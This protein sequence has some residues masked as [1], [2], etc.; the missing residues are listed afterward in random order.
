MAVYRIVSILVA[1]V[2]GLGPLGA[3][4]ALAAPPQNDNFNNWITVSDLPYVDTRDITDATYPQVG[5]PTPGC[6]PGGATYGKTVWYYLNFVFSIPR[7]TEILVST[8]GSNFDSVVAIYQTNGLGGSPPATLACSDDFNGTPQSQ[9]TWPT[10]SGHRT[11]VQVGVKGACPAEGCSL[12]LRVTVP[13]PAHDAFASAAT[14]ADPLPRE[15][16]AWTQEATTEDAGGEP[17]ITG[18]DCGLPNGLTTGRTIWYTYQPSATRE[19]VISSQASFARAVAVY[20]GGALDA[21]TRQGCRYFAAW[22]ST[23]EFRF[24]AQAGQTYRVQVGGVGSPGSVPGGFVQVNVVT[25]PPNDNFGQ[26]TTVPLPLPAEISTSSAGATVETGAGEPLPGADCG[27][28][29]ATGKTVWY[30]LTP[31]FSGPVEVTATNS[32]FDPVLAVY[33]G[34]SLGGLTR[35]GC[36]DDLD[37]NTGDAQVRLNAA[38]GTTYRIQVGGNNGGGGTFTLAVRRAPDNDDFVAAA[39]LNPAGLPV[40][41]TVDTRA[42][43]TETGE[44]LPDNACVS[45]GEGGGTEV[46][47][48]VWYRL[49]PTTNTAMVVSTADTDFQTVIAVYT[50]SAVNALTPVPNACGS[51]NDQTGSLVRFG[52]VAG[53]TYYIQIGGVGYYA[54]RGGDLRARFTVRPANDDV[55]GAST[56]P[57]AFPAEFRADT[58]GATTE[59]GEPAPDAACNPGGQETGRTLWYTVSPSPSPRTMEITTA[60]SD[61]AAFVAVYSVTGGGGFGGGLTSVACSTGSGGIGERRPGVAPRPPDTSSASV[62]LTTA[63]NTTYKVQVGSIGSGA[64]NLVATF[65]VP[66]GNDSFANAEVVSL[67]GLPKEIA[68]DTRAATVEAGEPSSTLCGRTMANTVWYKLTPTQTTPVTISTDASSIANTVVAVYTGGSLN[69][70]TEVECGD[71]HGDTRRGRLGF[72]AQAGTQYYVRLG[73]DQFR[74]PFGGT[75]RMRISAGP[76][77]D[78]VAT[79]TVVSSLPASLAATTTEATV[80]DYSRNEPYPRCLEDGQLGN[81]VWYSFTPAANATVVVSTLGSSY[82]TIVQVYTGADLNNLSALDGACND[83]VGGTQQSKVAF[84][85][86]AAERYLVQV[87]GKGQPLPAG[88]NLVIRFDLPLAITMADAPDPVVAG[89]TLTYT[90]DVTNNLPGSATGL[91]LTDTLPAGVT[92][93]SASAGC[94]NAAGTVTCNLG[95]LAAAEERTVTLQVR[96]TAAGSLSNTATVTGAGTSVSATQ[97]TTVTAAQARRTPFDVNADGKADAGIMRPGGGPGNTDLWYSPYTGGG[98]SF[99]IY[100]GAPGDL[101]VMGDYDGDGKADAAIYRP[102]T[103]LWYGVRTA[104]GTVAVQESIGWQSGDVPVPCDYNGDGWTDLAYFRPSTGQWFGLSIRTGARGVVL[105]IGP[106]VGQPGDLPA[107]ADYNGDGRCDAGIMRPGGGPGGTD[108]WYAPYT[109]GGGSFNIYFGAPGDLPMPGDYDG[110][111]KADAAIYRPSNGLWYGVRTATGTIAVQ[112]PLGGEAGDVPVP[113]DYNGDGW[114]DLGYYRPSNGSFF[115]LSI[116]TGARGVVLNTGPGV[117]Q[118]GDIPVQKRHGT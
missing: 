47:T 118:P 78:D 102:S 3:G 21:L 9:L 15:V 99:N 24:T 101:P 95:T 5:E 111:G 80:Q 44:V 53:T 66:A 60:G 110:D 105:N 92:F 116:K 46:D 38:S 112:E 52:A 61:Y 2:L 35:V 48:T 16:S 62:Q 25:P 32:A 27:D 28:V 88:G 11:M 71:Y 20:T 85:A 45:A 7:G 6:L 113:A 49:T 94:S 72:T 59:T 75:L 1:F 37:T 31:N 74:Q 69:S 19:V 34:S 22:S 10:Q 8:A 115:A 4:P 107:Q 13:A 43:S 73:G 36:N 58:L 30:T 108:L 79:P 33:T 40:A 14:I 76:P 87:M 86:Q 106:G 109:G 57:E 90:I 39:V 91:T 42:A 65:S 55:A 54:P 51:N 81:S 103:G 64:G 70:L 41:V 17:T 89:G 100:F 63:P 26:A 29:Q 56:V 117:G 97:T 12:R 82:D 77:N 18:P 93:L 98:G 50:G 84:A 23:D 96:P 68:V 114:T 67:T 104:T 83:D